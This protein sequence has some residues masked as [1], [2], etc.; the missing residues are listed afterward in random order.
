MLTPLR[1]E[2]YPYS[3][4]LVALAAWA[5]LLGVGYHLLR[6]SRARPAIVVTALVLSHWV[7]DALTHRPDLP[8]TL[9]GPERIGLGLW[10]AAAPAVALELLLFAAGVVLYARAT[11]AIDRTGRYALGG[12]VAFLVLVHVANLAG[13]PPPSPRAVAWISQALWLVV[14]WGS[15]IDRHRRPA[16]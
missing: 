3:H 11:R 6:R 1:F 14:A 13:P 15:W 8:L 7:L 9:R 2:H 16:T 10:N 4:S 5:L 12:L